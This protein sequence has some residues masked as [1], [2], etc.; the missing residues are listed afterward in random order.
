MAF[1]QSLMEL[2]NTAG[3]IW[4]VCIAV[5]VG[6]FIGTHVTNRFWQRV[7]KDSNERILELSKELT[8][9]E[10]ALHDKTMQYLDYADRLDRAHEANRLFRIENER[11]KAK[12]KGNARAA[13]KAGVI[14]VPMRDT[15]TLDLG[16]LPTPGGMEQEREPE[17]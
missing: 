10:D 17:S 2:D 6:A 8:K 1:R 9:A 15:I 14:T 11:L 7:N 3:W 5:F 16:E 13:K 12:A 4:V